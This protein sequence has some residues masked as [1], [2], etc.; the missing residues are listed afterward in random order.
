MHKSRNA[1]L[2]ITRG[3]LIVLVVVD[4]LFQY[5]LKNYAQDPLF[6]IIVS[7]YMPLFMIISGYIAFIT[8][9]NDSYFE[10]IKKKFLSL[11]VPFLAWGFLV[12]YLV[13]YSI[14]QI[15]FGDYAQLLF[16][17]P[18][19]GLWF[20]WVLFLCYLVYYSANSLSKVQ[21][22]I[23]SLLAE[24]ILVL[25]VVIILFIPTNYSYGFNLLRLHLP[26]FYTGILVARNYDFAKRILNRI[27]EIIF[28]A[29]PVLLIP[30]NRDSDP[31]FIVKIFSRLGE[32]IWI[33]ETIYK[34]LVAYTGSIFFVLL[35]KRLNNKF[36]KGIFEYLGKNSIDIYAIHL[37]FIIFLPLGGLLSTGVPIVNYLV[38]FTTAIIIVACC[39]FISNFVIKQSE[40]GSRI[41]LGRS[42]NKIN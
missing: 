42:L 39:L 14:H 27:K 16:Q 32:F 4:H 40:L 37:N 12:G 30:F 5:N 15:S 25:I 13:D 18:D 17:R 22:L 41:F 2:D 3:M 7:F 33:P 24:K 11:I 23:P 6:N 35:V 1:F 8:L 29:F 31:G 20:L 21:K 36:F 34:Y 19:A 9:R 26:Y 10:K 38:I 28:I